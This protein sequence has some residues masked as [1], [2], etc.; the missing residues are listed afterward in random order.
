[1]T[2]SNYYKSQTFLAKL[3]LPLQKFIAVASY[4][5]AKMLGYKAVYKK[6]SGYNA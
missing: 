3:P 1:M 5:V 2:W 6:Y 4:P